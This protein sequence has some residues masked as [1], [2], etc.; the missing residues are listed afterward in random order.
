MRAVPLILS[1]LAGL[2]AGLGATFAVVAHRVS[3]D[4]QR[5]GP[6]EFSA[7]VGSVEIDPYR[8]ARLFAEG[9][10]PLASGEGLALHARSDGTGAL[11]DGRCIYRVSG[12]MPVSRFWTLTL[13][14]PDGKLVRHPTERHGFTSSEILRFL[15][16]PAAIEIGAEPLAGN[17][18]PAPPTG[19]FALVFRFYD[20][21]LS[22]SATRLEARMVPIIERLECRP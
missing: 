12:P 9:E 2:A 13:S 8:R 22:S 5:L 6:W 10:L 15:D 18:L 7:R 14:R 17:W 16:K 19:N 4:Q 21:A 3:F 1:I 11:L 20:T